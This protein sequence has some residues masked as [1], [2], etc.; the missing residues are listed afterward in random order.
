MSILFLPT[1]PYSKSKAIM[2]NVK[3]LH[4]LSYFLPLPH[5]TRHIARD[6]AAATSRRTGIGREEIQERLPLRSRPIF[7]Y[8]QQALPYNFAKLASAFFMFFTLSSAA[9]NDLL[10]LSK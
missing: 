6:M 4:R 1:I 2:A 10:V 5:F 9:S 8:L 3:M 7:H